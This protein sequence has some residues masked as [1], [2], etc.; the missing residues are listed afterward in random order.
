[1]AFGVETR[2]PF[3]DHVLIE[4]ILQ[5]ATDDIITGRTKSVM[6]SAFRGKVP[7]E[8]LDQKGKFGFPSPIDHALRTDAQG[9]A[10]FY[11]HF[12]ETPDLDA[13]ETEKLA[14]NF[15]NN[16]GDVSIYWRT[17]SYILWY[18][19]FFKRQLQS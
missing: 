5:F 8:V 9:K 18:Q 2:V 12:R 16:N 7:D 19:V 14:D 4:F 13:A 6:R 10:L 17:L 1:M 11:D 15:Y 3:F